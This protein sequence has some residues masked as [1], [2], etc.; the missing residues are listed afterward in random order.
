M[1][2]ELKRCMSIERRWDRNEVWRESPD[3]EVII[4]I[5]I[6]IM[7]APAILYDNGGLAP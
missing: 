4:I 3:K 1:R 2:A 7:T 6:I 5:I